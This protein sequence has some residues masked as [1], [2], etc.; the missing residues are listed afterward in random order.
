MNDIMKT[1]YIFDNVKRTKSIETFTRDL[2][3]VFHITDKLLNTIEKRWN[4]NDLCE[5][6]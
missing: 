5:K 2:N 6:I 1:T 3:L 4:L